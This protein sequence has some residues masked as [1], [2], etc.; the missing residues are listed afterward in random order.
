L[1]KLKS[2]GFN[3]SSNYQ[4]IIVFLYK[5]QANAIKEINNL[6]F[7]LKQMKLHD[8]PLDAIKVYFF[9]VFFFIF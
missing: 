6:Q 4:D 1:E 7:H 8:N 9:S 5:Q 2:Y 3:A